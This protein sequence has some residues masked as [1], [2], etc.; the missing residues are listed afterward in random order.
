MDRVGDVLVSSEQRI[1][2]DPIEETDVSQAQGRRKSRSTTS[3]P[4]VA[5]DLR[6]QTMVF[7]GSTFAPAA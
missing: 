5:Q 1:G 7:H 4:L 6:A 2:D 3:M